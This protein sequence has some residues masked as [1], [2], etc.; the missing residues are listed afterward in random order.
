MCT[1]RLS[2]SY[3][4]FAQNF[5]KGPGSWC[6]FSGI[7]LE[8]L[9][10]KHLIALGFRH[11]GHWSQPAGIPRGNG[12]WEE[13]RPRLG[14]RIVSLRVT[15]HMGLLLVHKVR[16]IIATDWKVDGSHWSCPVWWQWLSLYSVSLKA[17]SIQLHKAESSDL[18]VTSP[19]LSS[20]ILPDSASSSNVGFFPHQHA[21]LRYQLCVLQFNSILTL[22]TWR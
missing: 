1:W 18:L 22:S 4:L 7:W 14:S 11:V 20:F 9:N 8:Q 12:R 19:C 5:S 6:D 16:S 13:V 21:I 3:F 10:T 17:V 15:R 2:Y